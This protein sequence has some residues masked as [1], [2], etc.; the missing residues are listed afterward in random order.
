MRYS[1]LWLFSNSALLRRLLFLLTMDVRFRCACVLTT[2]L[3]CAV[4]AVEAPGSDPRS[5]PSTAI[6]YVDWTLNVLFAVELAIKARRRFAC[7]DACMACAWAQPSDTQAPAMLSQL[8]VQGL[9]LHPGSLL[10]SLSGWVQLAALAGG[11]AGTV[12]PPRGLRVLRSLRCGTA[13]R[14]LTLCP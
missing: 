7:G 5:A 6:G 2:V 12:G 13:A 10:R 3:A 4:L 14:M 1:S 11:V 9:V 8:V